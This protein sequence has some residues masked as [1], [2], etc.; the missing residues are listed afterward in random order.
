LGQGQGP[1]KRV[2]EM[3]SRGPLGTTERVDLR[4]GSMIV[5]VASEYSSIGE[6]STA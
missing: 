4:S 1:E 6:A 2:I 5:A 3:A